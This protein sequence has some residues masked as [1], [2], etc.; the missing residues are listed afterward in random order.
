[1]KIAVLP[2]AY[3]KWFV[4]T[5]QYRL[6]RKRSKRQSKIAFR[7]YFYQRI[8]KNPTKNLDIILSRCYYNSCAAADEARK[9]LIKLNKE[10]KKCEKKVG[11]ARDQR[12]SEE[13]SL[14]KAIS[15]S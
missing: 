8:L 14:T 6:L 12:S 9:I 4:P 3:A 10:N 5:V 13:M 7:K 1:M 11:F 2:A 15:N